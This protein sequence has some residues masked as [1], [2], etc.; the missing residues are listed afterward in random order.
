MTGTSSSGH[1]ALVTGAGG[2]SGA[3]IV[4]AL[5]MAGWR[6]TAL[7]APWSA[8]RLAGRSGEGLVVKPCDL[9]FGIPDIGP[10]DMIV[11]TAARS[12]GPDV[13]ADAIARTNVMG[14]S[15]VATRAAVGDVRTV[16]NFSSLSVYGI[17]SAPEVDE[18][19]ARVDPDAYGQSKW[20]AEAVIAEGTGG[21]SVA[22]A[23]PA[24]HPRPRCRTQLAEPG[25]G[26]RAAGGDDHH[27]QS[28]RRL[29]QRGPC[30]RSGAIRRRSGRGWVVG[31]R[32]GH[33]GGRG[34]DHGATGGE[35][36]CRRGGK[37]LFDRRPAGATA[38]LHRVQPPRSGNIRL[39]AHGHRCDVGS[40]RRREPILRLY[41]WKK[42]D[43]REE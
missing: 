8:G 43:F 9:A 38:G 11:H 29:Q 22:V 2:M 34:A 16:I 7:V 14:A 24:G 36:A 4:D 15:S 35:A 31:T 32:R 3:A 37:P 26:R 40:V 27:R 23:A 5:L 10:L 33:P 41:R 18:G 6:V 1:H 42:A 28:R 12:P 25:V 17:V 13:G 30:G 19:T 21:V 39:P 20:L